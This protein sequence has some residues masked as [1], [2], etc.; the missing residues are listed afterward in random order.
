LNPE[1]ILLIVSGIGYQKKKIENVKVASDFTTTVN[2]ELSSDVVTLDA[3][4]VQA[5]APMIR[6]DLN[7]FKKHS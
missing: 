7:F 3:V 5:D 6:K 1:L 2:V 4:V